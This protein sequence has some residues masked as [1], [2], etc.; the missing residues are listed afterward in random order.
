MRTQNGRRGYCA[1]YI[2]TADPVGI[3]RKS[4]LYTILEYSVL[5]RLSAHTDRTILGV[6]EYNEEVTVIVSDPDPSKIKLE[7]FI[8]LELFVHSLGTYCTQHF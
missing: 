8:N 6:K 5:A 1:K 3:G 4:C 7:K 2:G